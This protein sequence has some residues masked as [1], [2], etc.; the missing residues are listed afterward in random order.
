M[1]SWL[2]EPKR[3]FSEGRATLTYRFK[4]RKTKK[5]TDN[6]L[7]RTLLGLKKYC[8][9]KGFEIFRHL[10]LMKMLILMKRMFVFYQACCFILSA[11]NMYIS[12]NLD[13]HVECISLMR[14]ILLL[15]LL[16]QR[17]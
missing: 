16:P 17:P 13:D 14:L 9:N 3:D 7:P 12:D 11:A 6:S 8:Q 5:K 1:D 4:N 2:G 15:L 10:A